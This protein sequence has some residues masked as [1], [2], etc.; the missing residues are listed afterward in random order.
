[1]SMTQFDKRA[2]PRAAQR[3]ISLIIALLC[4]IALTLAGLALIRS[5]DTTNVI[6]GNLAFRQ[7][8]LHTTD[9]GVETAFD[10]IDD[11]AAAT[12]LDRNYP[13]GC[14]TGGCT[15]YPTRQAT[16]SAGIPTVIN[17]TLVPST[18]VDNSYTVQYVLDRLCDAPTPVTDVRTQC[19]NTGA[20]IVGSK[21]AGVPSISKPVQVYYR[22][23]VRVVG[24]RNTESI[25]QALYAH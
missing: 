9:V 14:A 19:M 16:D 1:M 24:P 23:T 15:Y 3:G 6:S 21:K 25:V 11:I 10:K 5:T 17:W 8:A 18:T 20:A 7:A 13:S 2:K 22:A 12:S 4:L